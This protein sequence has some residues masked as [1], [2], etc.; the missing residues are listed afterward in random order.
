MIGLRTFCE[1]YD[2]LLN[3]IYDDIEKSDPEKDYE[4]L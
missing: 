3:E 2:K 1:K 4:D